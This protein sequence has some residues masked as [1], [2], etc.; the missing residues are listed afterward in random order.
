LDEA[1]AKNIDR[2]NSSYI[3]M[4]IVSGLEID[5]SLM[6]GYLAGIIFLDFRAVRKR[7]HIKTKI[8]VIILLN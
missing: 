6:C 3:E 1:A 7:F 5:N 4:W 2:M 8:E